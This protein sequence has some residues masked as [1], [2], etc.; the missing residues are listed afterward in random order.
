MRMTPQR[1]VILEELGK[2][3]SH[4]SADEVYVLARERLPHIS[5]GT[6]YRDLDLLAECGL[7]QR[8]ELR[9]QQRRYDGNPQ[10]HLH[11]R[12]NACGR[13]GDLAGCPEV[14]ISVEPLDASGFAVTGHRLEFTGI[15]PEC[16]REQGW[17]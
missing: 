10:E 4:P 7:I 16:R 13:V 12:C 9:G 3:T 8:L 11:I 2:V 6:V 1:R 5:L 15:C 14:N 17:V